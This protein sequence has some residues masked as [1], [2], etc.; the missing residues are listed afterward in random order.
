MLLGYGR[1]RS[2]IAVTVIV[3]RGTVEDLAEASLVALALKA[4]LVAPGLA[5]FSGNARSDVV[6]KT[7]LHPDRPILPLTC[8]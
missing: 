3:G 7:A 4:Q 5:R 2:T 8:K 1:G 6:V